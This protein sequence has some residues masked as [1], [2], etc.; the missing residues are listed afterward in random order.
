MPEKN[1]REYVKV[2]DVLIIGSGPAG[3]TAALYCARADRAPLVLEG[4]QPGGQLTTTT[5]V[6]NYPGC[7]EGISGF[8]LIQDMHKQAEHFGASFR[9]GSVVSAALKGA[10]KSVKLDDGETIEAKTIIIATGASARYLGIPSEKRF[11]GKGVSGCATCDGAFYRAKKVAVVGGG[12]TAM[13]D[14][15]YLARL[16]DK[17]TVIHRRDEFRASRI[18]A[19]RVERD[20]KIEIVWNTVVDEVL[21]ND[22]E[23]VTGVRLRNVLDNQAS[24]RAVSGLFVA[25]GH[26]PNT[27]PFA[28]ALDLDERG[29]I[30]NLPG[31]ASTG[32]EGV[33]A[34]GDVQDPVYRQAVTAAGSG[35]MA[36]LEVERYFAEHE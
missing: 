6:E 28:G 2:E 16:C 26:T 35:C 10:L 7:R 15:L 19:D 9:F 29:F 30:R 12:D 27:K 22:D 21:G 34:A 24:E 13:E 11:M 8:D 25:I 20:A 14:A 18:M 5:E 3:L 1:W 4:N 17:V 36:A 32:L 31:T 23:G 33:F